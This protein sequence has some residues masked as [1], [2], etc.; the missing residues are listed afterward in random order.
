VRTFL[1]AGKDVCARNLSR[2]RKNIL[3]HPVHENYSIHSVFD[4]LRLN[5]LA[6]AQ[7]KLPI[8]NDNKYIKKGV[9]WK[10]FEHLTD[11]FLPRMNR[12]RCSRV[13]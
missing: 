7:Y 2:R 9:L 1:R 12:V 4:A 13:P 11:T 10:S 8:V 6:Y 5:E 3:R